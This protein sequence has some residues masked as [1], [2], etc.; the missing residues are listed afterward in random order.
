MTA[1]GE[2]DHTNGDSSHALEQPWRR[3]SDGVWRVDGPVETEYVYD[4]VTGVLA[5]PSLEDEYG[6]S[7]D[8]GTS[9]KQ[10]VPN[11]L[12][13]DRIVTRSINSYLET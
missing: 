13:A 7:W 9:Y 4:A 12:E 10:Y 8:D 6:G 2:N 5:V 3:E 1:N 11:I